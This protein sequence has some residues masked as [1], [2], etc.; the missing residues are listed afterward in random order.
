MVEKSLEPDRKGVARHEQSM[1]PEKFKEIYD[2]HKISIYRFLCSLTKQQ[3]EADD[4]FQEV[5]LRAITR[6]PIQE[7]P[8]DAKSWLMKVA[9]NLHRDMLRRK[10]TV[11]SFLM[12]RSKRGTPEGS[13][14]ESKTSGS[15]RPDQVHNVERLR[16]QTKIRNAI[17]RLP[18]KQRRIFLLKETQQLRLIEIA[19]I[20]GIPLGTVKSLLHRAIKRL[21]R[22]LATNRSQ[23]EKS[24]CDAKMSSL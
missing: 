23:G 2:M 3:H 16:L 1:D 13:R 21:Q 15:C 10:R 24:K 19:D 18:E 6:L 14:L 12:S 7:K 17:D 4:L 9:L 11:R 22:E 5:W 20:L 8:Q